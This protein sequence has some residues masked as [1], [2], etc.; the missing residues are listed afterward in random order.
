M[1]TSL[2]PP[3]VKTSFNPPRSRR[4]LQSGVSKTAAGTVSDRGV[5]ADAMVTEAGADSPVL[6]VAGLRTELRVGGAWCAAVDDVSF[7]IGRS[8]TLAL[9]GESGSGK[10]MTALSVMGLVPHPAG[11]IAAGSVR[12]A[13]TELIGLPE[14][15]LARLRGDRMAMIFQDPMTSLN[16]VMT[17]GRQVAESLRIHRGLRRAEAEARALAMLEEVKIPSA[18]RR[19]HDFPHQFS[20]GMRQRVMI[21]LALACEPALLLA[22]EPTTALDV[23]IQAEVLALLG[24]LQRRHGMAMLF[25]THNLGVVAQI[26]DRVAVMY[27]GQIVEEAGVDAIFAAPAHPYTRALFAAIPDLE[28]GARTLAAIPG[29]VPALGSMPPGCRFAPRCPLA[30]AGCDRPQVLAPAGEGHFAR[31][32][33]ATGVEPPG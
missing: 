27:A 19:F 2:R 21:A 6:R 5:A 26:A 1:A 23:T 29:R 13:G 24:D 8:E 17:V 22:D 3:F 28:Q 33:V 9:V 18:A 12:L 20:G 11:R 25:I 15:A 4:R 31:C 14:A 32:H 16:P 10:S 30:R 7:A